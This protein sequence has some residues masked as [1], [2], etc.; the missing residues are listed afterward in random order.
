MSHELRT[1]LNA[2]L[3]YTEMLVDGVYGE[4]AGEALEILEYIQSNGG[5]FWHS[6]TMF[7]TSRRLRPGNSRCPSTTMRYK[8]WSR[9]SS[10]LRSRSHRPRVLTSRSALEANC[11]WGGATSVG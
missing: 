1:P 7:S 2:V 9:L 11:R 5:T 6:S 3:G 10:L 4:M 8:A